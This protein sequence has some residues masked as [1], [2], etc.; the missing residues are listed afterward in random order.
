MDDYCGSAAIWPNFS[1]IAENETGR[2]LALLPECLWFSVLS[3]VPPAWLTLAFPFFISDIRKKRRNAL[4]FSAIFITKIIF[5][6]VNL[7][8]PVV[9]LVLLEDD[10]VTGAYVS[11]GLM[12]FGA[13]LYLLMTHL[14]RSHG[15]I[16][17]GTL[18]L[19]WVFSTAA[20][21]FYWTSVYQRWK[22]PSYIID[23]STWEQSVSTTQFAIFTSQAALSAVNFVLMAF[24]EE[25]EDDY[26]DGSYESPISWLSA[27]FYSFLTPVIWLGWIK[28]KEGDKKGLQEEDIKNVKSR[29]RTENYFDQFE[30]NWLAE[31]ARVSEIN[32]RNAAKP[33]KTKKPRKKLNKVEAE[34]VEDKEEDDGRVKP[35]L[36][37]VLWNTFRH[38]V[39]ITAGWKLFNDVLVFI[40]PQILNAILGYLE[41]GAQEPQWTGFLYAVSLFLVACATTFV[42]QRYWYH[43]TRVG[44]KVRCVLTAKIYRK[45]LKVNFSNESSTVGEVVNYMSV[46]AQRF[47]DTA[48]F[49]NFLWSAPLQIALSLY[50]LYVQLD[51]ASFTALLVFFIL[52]PLS[53]FVTGKMR[54]LI[55][56][57]MKKRDGRMK[58]MNEI[59]NG[60]KVLKLYAWEI[61]FMDRINK[62]RFDELGLIKKYS[63]LQAVVILIWEFTPYLVQL[64]CFTFYTT[65]VNGGQEL[66]ATTVYTSLSLF[67]II[68]FPINMLPMVVIMVTMTNVASDRITKFLICD[69]LETSNLTRSKS[70][71]GAE[72]AISISKGSHSYKKTGEMALNDIELKVSSGN[73]VAVVGPV[74]SGKSSMISTLLGELHSD[75]SKIHI[76]GNLAYVPQQAWIQNM[77]LK[78]NIIFGKEFNKQKYEDIIDRCCLLSDIDILE[79]G[80]ST[81]IGERGINLSGGQKQRVS[82]ARA[83]YSEADIYLFDDPLSAVDAHVGRR[84][85]DKVL[86]PEGYLKNKTRL[87]VTHST[88]YLPNCDRIIVMET[89][90]KILATGTL[91]QLKAMNNER[92]EEIIS[93]KVKEENEEKEKVDKEGEKKNKK[94]EKDKN[95][96]NLVT[97]E[98]A[99]ESGGGLGVIKSYFKAFGYGWMSFYI[100]AA[101]IYMLADM[102]YNIWLTT[103]VDAIIFYNETDSKNNSCGYGAPYVQDIF[104]TE[105]CRGDSFYLLVYG[106]IGLAVALLSYTRSIINIQG[107]IASG[108]AFHK[109]LLYGIMRS[110]MSFFDTTPTGRIVNRFGKDIDSVDNNIPQS[111]RQWI[112]CLLRIVSTVIILSRT[113]IWFLLIVPILCL[114]FMLIERFY[115]AANRQLKRLESTTR[116]PIYSSFGETISGTSVIRA[117]QK[118]DEFIQDNLNK[119]DHNLKFQY[120]NLMCNRWL[121]IRLE[122]FAN[123]IVFS[124]AIYAVLSKNSGSS[125]ADIGLALS[126]S[127][128]VTQILNFLI[129][130]TAELE[131]NL[132]AVERIEEYCNLPPEDSWVK[133]GTEWMKKG[134]T[135]MKDYALR[136]RDGLP[137]VLKGLDCKISAGEKIGIVGRTGAGKSSLTVGLFRLV[138]CARGKIEIDGVDLSKLGLHDLRK[139]LTIIPQ[140]PVLF[141]GTLREN[142]DPF[143]DATDDRIWEALRLA[144]LK[145]TV[146]G[147]E[148]KL[149]H[150]VNENGS[151]LS[152]GER[153]L[154]CLARALL[155]DSKVLVLDEATSAVDNNTDSLIQKTIRESFSGLTILTIA[156]R[157]NTIIDY[158]RVMVLD[159]GKIV[160][161]DSPEALFSKKDGIFRSMCDEANVKQ[162][163]ILNAK[164]GAPPTYPEN[165]KEEK[166]KDRRPTPPPPSPSKPVDETS[167]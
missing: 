96:G 38:E 98:G 69:E 162:S 100:F 78:D 153:Q 141:S 163:D 122:S 130:S 143:N 125:A 67:N 144:H 110:P 15:S 117:Y 132:V 50:F 32:A 147:F 138:E 116:S 65:L 106:C 136:Y 118:E 109:N 30:K 79:G 88:Q 75:S 18:T 86:G 131:V 87:F 61:P 25:L 157:L 80:D 24:P 47:Q 128:S 59:L 9:N 111:I 49:M 45:G 113:E 105:Q 37:R 142:L 149:E 121:G 28:T 82:I 107:I 4:S 48:T 70:S 12:I 2:E 40:N 124:V 151:N 135:V 46:D 83:V 148:K 66:T 146:S 81:E 120:A 5:G 10:A 101:L 123:L 76:N 17:S 62:I 161:L 95:A 52:T 44:V 140:E 33:S 68:R 8:L 133:G 154:V 22:M 152:V 156:H 127:M 115:I 160:E 55:G 34:K 158:D 56:A 112:S 11:N 27:S 89:G 74:G 150:E 119:V 23:P 137:L 1:A 71:K 91:D 3:I 93:V 164:L 77:T 165:E 102:M 134:R 103:W 36:Y 85:F 31:V 94:D 155:R 145:T 6:L 73:I 99:D 60:I 7:A 126:Y 139:R 39:L 64:T 54:N 21:W 108:R 26:F 42:L 13:F 35:S 43:C 14:Q 159:D 129:R 16:T 90:G 19:Y 29:D 63:Y 166:K 72:Y 58:L 84:I 57:N 92:I 97:K 20:F 53:G 51:W 41:P 167:F 104:K 114:V